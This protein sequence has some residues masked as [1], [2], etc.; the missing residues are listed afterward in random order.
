[1]I[2][3]ANTVNLSNSSSVAEDAYTPNTIMGVPWLS[4]KVSS[5]VAEDGKAWKVTK[6]EKT[7]LV[8]FDPDS[9]V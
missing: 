9:C 1:M 7:P 4:K 3:R 6:F 2:S 5:V 8:R